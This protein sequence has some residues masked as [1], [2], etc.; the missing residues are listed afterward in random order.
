MEDAAD[1][2]R[3]PAPRGFDLGIHAF[4]KINLGLRVGARRADGYHEILT[5]FQTLD[6]ADTL[7]ARPRRH[8]FRLRVRKTGPAR[9]RGLISKVVDCAWPCTTRS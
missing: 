9:G 3:Q 2:L 7:Y 8:G 4:C 1:L 5:V 6:F